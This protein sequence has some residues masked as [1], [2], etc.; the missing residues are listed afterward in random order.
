MKQNVKLQ[1]WAKVLRQ[2][3]EFDSQLPAC[4][5]RLSSWLSSC[6]VVMIWVSTYTYTLIAWNLMNVRLWSM[7]EST[8]ISCKFAVIFDAFTA[9]YCAYVYRHVR[10]SYS[11]TSVTT[12]TVFNSDGVGWVICIRWCVVMS[13]LCVIRKVM[14]I[15]WCCIIVW[16]HHHNMRM[17]HSILSVYTNSSVLNTMVYVVSA[18]Q[19]CMSMN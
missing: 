3:I 11:Q 18:Y 13:V 14:Q 6:L 15:W 7:R 16:L 2:L 17:M 12:H 1:S 9:S 8:R 5:D 19:L 4:T 10:H